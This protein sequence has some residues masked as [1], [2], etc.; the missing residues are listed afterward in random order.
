MENVNENGVITNREAMSLHQAIID[1]SNSTTNMPGKV[2][3]AL[4]KNQKKLESAIK[5]IESTR[6]KVLEAHVEKNDDGSLKMTE[7]TEE[8][9]GQGMR[10]L[11]V[12]K[13]EDD[14][15]QARDKFN[16]LLEEEADV[17]LHML[18]LSTFEKLVI[19]TQRVNFLDL[20]V[21]RIVFEDAIPQMAKL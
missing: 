7:P 10:P 19:N 9:I 18:P 11:Y 14:E 16:E 12:Y 3:Y 20:F 4:T 1:I 13:S 8:E 6:V 15:G 21:D 17:E 2:I 5:L